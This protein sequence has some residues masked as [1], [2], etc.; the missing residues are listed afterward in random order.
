MGDTDAV[1]LCDADRACEGVGDSAWLCVSDALGE[2]VSDWLDDAVC[3]AEGVRE[4]EGDCV[5]V[6]LAD[7]ELLGDRVDRALGVSEG[8]GV[9]VPVR[10]AC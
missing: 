2:R 1:W 5:G 6:C 4:A 10:V 8:D 9:V 3:D 7:C